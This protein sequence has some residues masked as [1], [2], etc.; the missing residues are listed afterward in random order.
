MK[1]QY[2]LLL[3]FIATQSIH[4]EVLY[5][6][7]FDDLTDWQTQ[8]R[9]TL[10]S[11]PGDFDEGITA[12]L[13]HPS[14]VPNSMPSIY[15]SG[16]NPN[17]VYGEKGKA[18]ILTYESIGG[19]TN[20]GSWPSDG[21]LIKDISPSNEVYVR[22]RIKFQKDFLTNAD[23]NGG[24]AKIFRIASFDGTVG[25]KTFGKSGS[26]SPVYFF[27]WGGSLQWGARHIHAFRCDDQ[28]ITYYCNKPEIQ[29]A[30]RTVSRGSISANFT[31]NIVSLGAKL[32]DLLNGGIL[33]D[34]GSIEHNQ[35]YGDVWHTV[36]YFVK[37]NS[38]PNAVD[39]E[40]KFWLDEQPLID[41]KMIPWI[42]SNGSMGAKWNRVLFGG[43]GI[44]DFNTNSDAPVTARERWVAID[45]IIVLDGLPKKP[46]SPNN[47]RFEKT[48]SN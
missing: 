24:L 36:E 46:T 25:G 48:S 31:S 34:T 44:F 35:V 17:Q 4:A 10:G 37:L 18:L 23:E 5:Q 40:F 9:S 42:G 22:F 33:P 38:S 39:G 6:Q 16:E 11:L 26:H 28:A 29:D 1:I 32:P 21:V 43:N 13:W 15:I 12:E 14:E 8:G 41:M 19:L 27:D 30:P 20:S 3:M 7:N 47:F 45:D 2:W